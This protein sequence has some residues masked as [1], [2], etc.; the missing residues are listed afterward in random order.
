M[1]RL[2]AVFWFLGALLPSPAATEDEAVVARLYARGLGGDKQAVIDC[3][4]TLE[5]VL[6]AE[7][8]NQLARVYLGSAETLRSRDLPF[9][10]TKL[11]TLRRG[12]ARMDE[13]AAAAP[14]D[15]KVLLLRAITNEALPAL[16]GRRQAAR[17][18]L[19]ELVALVEKEP[20]KL[21]PGDRQ[22]LYLN[23][24]NAGKSA[25][26]N[27]RARMLWERGLELHADPKLQRE[28]QAAR[29]TLN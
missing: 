16:L 2:L 19:E 1:L 12:I 18:A 23:A 20:A 5:K 8:Q 3:I 21:S 24:G 11:S 10:P 29:A 9:G 26:D 4:A 15:G 14:N 7:P 6:A 17:Q 13:A 28:L 25:G 22:L 27:G